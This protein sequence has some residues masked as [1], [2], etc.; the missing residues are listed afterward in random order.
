MKDKTRHSRALDAEIIS[1]PEQRARQ[2]VLNGLKQFDV[3]VQ[4][5]ETF[6]DS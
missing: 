3:V 6:L 4:M 2:E 1:D 5:V